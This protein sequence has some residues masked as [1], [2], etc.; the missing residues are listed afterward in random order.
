MEESWRQWIG[1]EVK[2]SVTEVKGKLEIEKN[3]KDLF[4]DEGGIIHREEVTLRDSRTCVY[5]GN[6]DTFED[7]YTIDKEGILYVR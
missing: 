7:R 3:E 1:K 2:D 4:M 5:F 6:A